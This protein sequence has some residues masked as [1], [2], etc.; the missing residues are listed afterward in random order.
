MQPTQHDLRCECP[1]HL[2]LAKYGRTST[3]AAYV[4]IESYKGREPRTKVYTTESVSLWCRACGRWMNV[5]IK[6]QKMTVRERS[7]PPELVGFKPPTSV[8]LDNP[9]STQ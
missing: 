4:L 7:A 9:T 3:G 8:L 6:N 2:M 5:Q 1:A